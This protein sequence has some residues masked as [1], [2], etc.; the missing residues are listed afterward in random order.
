MTWIDS[1]EHAKVLPVGGRVFELTNYRRPFE[2]YGIDLTYEMLLVRFIDD[3]SEM[4][5]S[6]ALWEAGWRELKP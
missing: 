3:H 5:V 4:M 2:I 1:L 6:R